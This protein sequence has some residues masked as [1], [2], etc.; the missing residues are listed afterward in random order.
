[1]LLDQAAVGLAILP[2][3]PQYVV[4]A[5]A[6]EESAGDEQEIRQAV[7]VL[8]RRRRHLLARLVGKL[9]HQPLAAP[10][11]RAGEMQMGGRRRAAGQHE[12]AQ[13][14]ELGIECVDLLLEPRHLRV[15]DGEPRA[16][17]PLALGLIGRAE[18]GAEIEQVVLD[19]RQHGVDRRLVPG[20]QARKAEA[21]VELVDGAVGGDAQVVLLAPLAGAERGGS[22]IAGA[23]IDAVEDDHG[24][25]RYFC[26]SQ[27][28]AMMMT[29]AMNCST[30]RQRISFCDVF[31]EP[32]RSMLARPSTSTMA[33]APTAIGTRYRA[34]KSDIALS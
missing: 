34:K 20:V 1:M 8:E 17:R 3:H 32:P 11:H 24:R 26:M 30:T 13:R 31:G 14:A 19:A 12:R 6:I 29:I 7:D 28:V 23:R 2:R 22:V 21:G 9:D 25:R 10:A 33:T 4:G 18:I 27:I 5:F 15:A 16:A